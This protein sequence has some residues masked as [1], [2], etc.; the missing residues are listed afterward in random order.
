M[1]LSLA[2]CRPRYVLSSKQMRAVLHDL[3]RAD[4]ILQVAGY[5]YGNDEALAKYYQRVLDKHG[6]TQAQFDSSLVWYTDHPQRF[7]KIYPR[8]VASLEEENKQWLALHASTALTASDTPTIPEDTTQMRIAMEESAQ[9][10]HELLWQL[11]HGLR[12]RYLLGD[13]MDIPR[14]TLPILL[15]MGLDVHT[16]TLSIPICEQNLISPQPDCNALIPSST[17]LF[18]NKSH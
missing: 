3:H 17:S 14:D 15:P 5:N 16:D 2:G 12:V 11:Q 4:A 8:V 9:A 7:D 6:I 1:L 18:R 13:S 10:L